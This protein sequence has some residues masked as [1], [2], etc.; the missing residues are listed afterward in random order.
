MRHILLSAHFDTT[1]TPQRLTFVERMQAVLPKDVRLVVFNLSGDAASK[2]VEVV[3]GY[4]STPDPTRDAED[5]LRA[6]M[7]SLLDKRSASLFEHAIGEIATLGGNTKRQVVGFIHKI[8][9]LVAAIDKYAPEHVYLWNQFNAFHCFAEEYIRQRGIGVGFFHEGVL[10]GSIAFDFDAEMGASWVS[11]K[12]QLLDSIPIDDGRLL[13]A[14]RFLQWAA[15]ESLSRHEQ[16]EKILVKE[17]LELA[18]LAGKKTIFYAGQNDWHAGIQPDGNRRMEH[19]PLYASSTAPL[20]DLA[21]V[22][23]KNDWAVIFKPHPLDRDKYVFLRA[24]EFENTLILVSTDVNACIDACDVLVTIASQ[25]AYVAAMRGKPVVMLGRNQIV[26]KNLTYDVTEREE[27]EA[28]I[29]EAL[30]D[31]LKAS[32]EHDLAVHAA[33]LERAYLFDFGLYENEF[34]GR[35]PQEAAHWLA[36]AMGRP[37]EETVEALVRAVGGHVGDA[38]A[39]DLA[40]ASDTGT[41]A[42]ADAEISDTGAAA[43]ATAEVEPSSAEASSMEDVEAAPAEIAMSEIG[44]AVEETPG[45]G[46]TDRPLA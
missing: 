7:T 1:K 34:Y 35:G 18:D 32:R 31:P 21:A 9:R 36:F 16:V 20:A 12:P 5:R 6:R 33:R 44:I 22:A 11:K 19:S 37:P 17:S 2:V 39:N 25:T 30:D 23:V 46:G 42:A 40:E 45:E 41:G 43:E 28:K 27:L 3:Q 13:A 26:G 29:L 4:V 38:S 10:P 8:D 24:D 15:N 14:R